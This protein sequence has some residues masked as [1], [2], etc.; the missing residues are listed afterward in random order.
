M[1]R[2]LIVYVIDADG[3]NFLLGKE[4]SK[5][6]RVSM[7]YERN[8]LEFKEKKKSV[9]LIESRGGICWLSCNW[10]QM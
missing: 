7:D 3:V 10:L 1:K 5:I 4:T 8:K 9:G 2:G 6:W